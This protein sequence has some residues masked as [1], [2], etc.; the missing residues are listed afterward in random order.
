MSPVGRIMRS[1]RD[2]CATLSRDSYGHTLNKYRLDYVTPPQKLLSLRGVR[3]GTFYLRDVFTEIR[4]GKRLK[5][6]DHITGNVP[7]VSSSAINNGVDNFIGNND[8]VRKFN[9]CMTIANS[10]SVG[11]TFYHDYEFVASD[12]I[13]A[14]KAPNM[15]RYIYLFIAAMAQR[16]EEKYSFNREINETR[17]NRE[18]IMLPPAPSGLPDWQLMHSYML[19]LE[20]QCLSA[21]IN[22]FTA[23]LHSGV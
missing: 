15:D 2:S 9:D 13:T 23:K 7:Y 8:G 11:K 12:H 17:I 19:S 3:W 4:R 18:K 1:W 20:S 6:E 14:L 16:L 5:T 10:G 21:V 22:H